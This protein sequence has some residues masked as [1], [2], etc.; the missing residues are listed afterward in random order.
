MAA[1]GAPFW[2]EGGHLIQGIDNCPRKLR[3]MLKRL[4]L[5]GWDKPAGTNADR[6]DAIRNAANR[7]DLRG[8]EPPYETQWTREIGEGKPV[9]MWW[10]AKKLKFQTGPTRKRE[11]AAAGSGKRPRVGASGTTAAT[12]ATTAAPLAVP[13]SPPPPPPGAT[14]A[15]AA[16]A[17]D[18]PLLL[19]EVEL[20]AFVGR[21]LT[22]GSL[23]EV[24]WRFENPLAVGAVCTVE[25]DGDDEQYKGKIIEV[26]TD[27]RRVKVKYDDGEEHWEAR[28]SLLGP[29]N[30]FHWL[31]ATLQWDAGSKEWQLHYKDGDDDICPVHFISA[32]ELQHDDVS[33]QWRQE[34]KTASSSDRELE[35]PA[36]GVFDHALD[37]A[38][39]NLRG[40]DVSKDRVRRLEVMRQQFDELLT[41]YMRSLTD[42]DAQ[43]TEDV[44]GAIMRGL[45]ARE[46]RSEGIV[47]QSSSLWIEPAR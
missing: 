38:I 31:S 18:M 45:L 33:Q 11:A 7:D 9:V 22:V 3:G 36:Y 32:D 28:E 20:S 24:L 39:K 17:D 14:V 4:E 44:V 25:W 47:P 26:Q 35:G 1:A 46:V 27:G 23:L 10:N 5:P 29:H 16:T 30:D 13:P 19:R 15:A 43:V 37:E 34:E 8:A 12:T 6:W 2:G 41:S 40:G 21:R 42:P